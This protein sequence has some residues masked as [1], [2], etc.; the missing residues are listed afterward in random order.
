MRSL[1]LE[2]HMLR[3]YRSL[4]LYVTGFGCD[5]L[6][7][8]LLLIAY[9]LYGINLRFEKKPGLDEDG[10]PVGGNWSL[11]ADVKKGS[12][13][14]YKYGGTTFAPHVKFYREGQ[15]LLEGW[16]PLQ[17]HEERHSEQL[18]AA[19]VA[20]TLIAV[21]VAFSSLPLTIAIYVLSPWVIMLAA[22]VTGWLRGEGIYR[23]AHTEEAAYS[24]GDAH[25]P[26][27]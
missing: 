9:P 20:G 22:N 25:K 27:R 11:T 24:I 26:V 10:E 3:T 15:R 23:G 21:A 1:R 4:L 8:T 18:Q 19:S 5:L 17:E 16:N 14:F 7:A 12:A 2:V 6:S 13:E